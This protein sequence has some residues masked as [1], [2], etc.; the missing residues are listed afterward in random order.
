VTRIA[1]TCDRL[2]RLFLSK[3]ADAATPDGRREE[4]Y[5]RAARTA[6]AAIASRATGV[7]TVLATVPLT[8]AYLGP[9][10]FGLWMALAGFVS[11]LAFADL[12]LGTGLQNALA[13]CHGRD[14]RRTPRSLISTSLVAMT[15]VFALMAGL[16]VFVVPHLP[17][18]AMFRLETEPAR[19]EITGTAQALLIAFALGLPTSLMPRIYDAYQEGYWGHLWSAAGRIV[20]LVGVI[21]CI[22]MKASL[23]VL[24]AV[25]MVAPFGCLA[26]GTVVLFLRRPALRPSLGSVNWGSLAGMSRV[27]VA[28]VGV[29]IAV[30]IMI[31]GPAVVIASRMGA[32]TVTEFFVTQRLLALPVSLVSVVAV[33][34]WPAYGEAAARGDM[35]W[36]KQAFRG[37]CRLGLVVYGPVLVIMMFCGQWI[38]RVW[39]GEPAAVPSFSLLAAC[40]VWGA[41]AAWNATASM[42]LAGLNRM[43]GQAIYGLSFAMLAMG[44][45]YVAAPNCSIET[46]TWLMVLAGLLTNGI[47]LG[48]EVAWRLHRM[49]G[50]PAAC[51]VEGCH[52]LLASRALPEALVASNQ[53][54][55]AIEQ[56]Q[57]TSTVSI[58]EQE[59]P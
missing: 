43:T 51:A 19:A 3:S 7:L 22:W 56:R 34:L 28:A 10:R 14:D 18:A 6:A 27:A 12:G 48:V 40:T 4:R 33:A 26:I 31:H 11:L 57:S 2:L 37:S 29:Q 58:S 5:R 16:A 59:M 15:A 25:F 9:E 8:L 52:G 47:A 49:A 36:V 32:A 50:R 41:I 54:H 42:L 1:G 17:L 23:P 24:A 44:V 21:V 55:P 35:K 20:G 46:V 30:M 13:E 53:W 39:T 45:A 38:I